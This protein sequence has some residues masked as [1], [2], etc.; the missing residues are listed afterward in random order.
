MEKSTATSKSKLDKKLLFIIGTILVLVVAGVF[1]WMKLKPTESNTNDST[2]ESSNP[3]EIF[4]SNPDKTYKCNDYLGFGYSFEI[5]Y[6]DDGLVSVSTSNGSADLETERK[7]LEETYQG[8]IENYINT[9]KA[10]CED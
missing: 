2:Q 7:R 9:V 10:L 3:L 4:E 8:N 1:V 5:V 6:N